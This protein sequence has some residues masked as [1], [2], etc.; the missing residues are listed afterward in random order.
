MLKGSV[1]RDPLFLIF[2]MDKT[3]VLPNI[4]HNANLISVM[5][6]FLIFV[7]LFFA[8]RGNINLHHFNDV[9]Y[10]SSSITNNWNND[11]IWGGT[12]MITPQNNSVKLK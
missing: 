2:V 5:F 7:F 6:A 8:I 1:F 10:K 3:I 9:I 4:N 12:L 11:S